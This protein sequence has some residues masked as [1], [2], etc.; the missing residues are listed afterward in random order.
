[1]DDDSRPSDGMGDGDD[2][3]P[4]EYREV[5][6]YPVVPKNPSLSPHPEGLALELVLQTAPPEEILAA[7]GLSTAQFAAIAQTPAFKKEFEGYLEMSKEDGFSYKMKSR[8]QADGMLKVQWEMVHNEDTPASVRADLI[9]FVARV[10]GYDK[11]DVRGGDDDGVSREKITINI[12][13][14]PEGTSD[15]IKTISS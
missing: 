15:N 14:G 6:D 4:G 9:K 1:M 11:K 12:N 7:Y 5:R 2:N 10:A 8:A 13:L 3:L